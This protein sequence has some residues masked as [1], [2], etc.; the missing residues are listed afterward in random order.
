M[1]CQRFIDIF[2]TLFNYYPTIK[3]ISS[4]IRYNKRNKKQTQIDRKIELEIK[5]S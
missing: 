2:K 3:P 4:F 1:V 5:Q